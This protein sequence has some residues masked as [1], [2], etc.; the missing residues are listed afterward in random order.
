MSAAA[1]SNWPQA[2]VIVCMSAS[3]NEIHPS[4]MIEAAVQRLNPIDQHASGSGFVQS[5]CCECHAVARWH[6]NQ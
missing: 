3:E 5:A 1:R 2:T 4:S 6:R